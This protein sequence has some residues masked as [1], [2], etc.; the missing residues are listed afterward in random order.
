MLNI[1]TEQFGL[2]DEDQYLRPFLDHQSGFAASPTWIGNN[3][4]GFLNRPTTRRL[5]FTDDAQTKAAT[6]N[7]V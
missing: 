5:S 6:M 4:N 7:Y 2:D 3:R 1:S